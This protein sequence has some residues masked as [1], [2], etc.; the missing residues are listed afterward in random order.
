MIKIR[1][2][3]KDWT[4]NTIDPRETEIIPKQRFALEG[5]QSDT[6]A[7]IYL[8]FLTLYRV[9]LRNLRERPNNFDLL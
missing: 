8:H 7:N 6:S 5:P 3:R 1:L 4:T 9:R 2:V